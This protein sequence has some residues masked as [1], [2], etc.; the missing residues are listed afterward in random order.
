MS[1]AP[2]TEIS[3]DDKNNGIVL[4]FGQPISYNLYTFLHSK[5]CRPIA[6]QTDLTFADLQFSSRSTRLLL[7]V[8]HSYESET[9]VVL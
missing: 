8:Q 5:A 1:P 7:T 2:A 4:T 3:S 6:N 9:R